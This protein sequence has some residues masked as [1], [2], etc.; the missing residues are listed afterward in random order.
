MLKNYAEYFSFRC[1]AIELTIRIISARARVPVSAPRVSTPT[2]KMR[3]A[4]PGTKYWCISSLTEYRALH[5]TAITGEK[6]LRLRNS[7]Q[8]TRNPRAAYSKKCANFRTIKLPSG[9]PS[10]F[11]KIPRTLSLMFCD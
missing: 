1:I 6:C 5:I 2:S 9:E 8:P 7:A 10:I 11:A 4:R 3:Q